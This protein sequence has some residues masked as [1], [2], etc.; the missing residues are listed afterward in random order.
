MSR[1]SE[2]P[3]SASS[4]L[5][6]TCGKCLAK[7]GQIKCGRCDATTDVR[8]RLLDE[9]RHTAFYLSA[10]AMTA[11]LTRADAPP[12]KITIVPTGQSR[13]YV[14]YMPADD[15]LLYTVADRKKQLVVL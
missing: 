5:R 3:D 12:V 8:P 9:A 11:Q 13:G 10:L 2:T 15:R 4:D 6:C 1:T 14:Q 7:G